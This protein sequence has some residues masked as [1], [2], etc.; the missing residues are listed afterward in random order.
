MQGLPQTTHIYKAIHVKMMGLSEL[1]VM[2][3]GT[4]FRRRRLGVDLTG[5]GALN[6]YLKEGF[7]E[8]RHYSVNTNIV[9]IHSTHILSSSLHMYNGIV[10]IKTPF[11]HQFP[12]QLVHKAIG[13]HVVDSCLTGGTTINVGDTTFA[14]AVHAGL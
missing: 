8:S 9:P 14:K 6:C 7:G 11:L 3:P 4:W 1:D 10:I 2:A 5:G 13:T 12:H